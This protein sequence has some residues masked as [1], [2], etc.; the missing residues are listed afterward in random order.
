[1]FSSPST[2]AVVSGPDIVLISPLFGVVGGS[3]AGWVMLLME[4]NLALTD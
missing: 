2:V 4:G 3:W 1:M